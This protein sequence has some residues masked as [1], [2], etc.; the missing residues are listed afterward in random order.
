MNLKTDRFE[1][2]RITLTDCASSRE[3]TTCFKSKNK[4]QVLLARVH[5]LIFKWTLQLEHVLK[6]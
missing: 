1:D 6:R 4:K 5:E 2:R 3:N